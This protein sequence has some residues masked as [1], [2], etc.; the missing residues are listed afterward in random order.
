VTPS[1]RMNALFRAACFL[2][3]CCIAFAAVYPNL[4]MLFSSLKTS[5]DFINSPL[6]LPNEWYFDNFKALYYRFSLVNLYGNTAFCVATALFFSLLLSLPSAYAF[7]K[8]RFRYRRPLYVTMIAAM[9]IPG[10]TFI[11]PDFLLISKLGLVDHL[12]AVTI[13]WTVTSIPGNV[14][15]LASLMRG[16]PNEVLEAVKID[17]G[18]Y[19]QLMAHVVVP[20]SLPGIFT[21][22][23]FNATGWWNDLLTP[24]IFLQSDANKTMT[25]A[26]ATILGRFSSD[27]PLLLTGMLLTSLP[28]VILY[29]LLQGFIRKGLV[30]GAVK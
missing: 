5:V 21:V 4:F 6:S 11:L 28:T 25:V 13:I 8:M 30:I 9:M 20:I 14:F 27:F 2:F 22:A 16:L 10:I 24:L 19:Y 1:N 29:I 15:L 12:I 26:V 18:N 3:L 7:A 17:G 23:I